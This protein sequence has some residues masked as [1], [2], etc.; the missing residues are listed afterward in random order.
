VNRTA[1]S[2]VVPVYSGEEYLEELVATLADV[3]EDWSRRHPEIELAEA[4]LVNDSAIDASPEIAARLAEKYEWVETITLA[5]NYGQHPA[6]VCGVLHASG[7]WIVTMDED[8]QHRPEHIETLLR[9]AVTEQVDIVYAAP[10]GAVHGSWRR[11]FSSRMYKRMLAYFARNPAIRHFSSF[12]MCRGTVARAGA[13]VAG[14]ETYFDVSLTWFTDRFSF[15]TVPMVDSRF[16]EA[17]RSGYSLGRLIA[18]AR[19]LMI[20]SHTRL[21]RLVAYLGILAIS[22]AGFFGLRALWSQITGTPDGTVAGWPSLFVSVLFFGGLTAF[23]LVVVFEYL[24]NVVLHTQ[25]KPTY[26][27]VDR[28]ADA[29]VAASLGARRDGPADH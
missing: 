24:M 25:G 22:L 9:R 4:I 16:Q 27:V 5:R 1:V 21:V 14:H 8:L 28:S 26:F 3:R 10:E 23:L 19:R 15:V 11:D 13:S 20:S 2:V 18:H 12:R 6:T 17:G 7:D 29:E